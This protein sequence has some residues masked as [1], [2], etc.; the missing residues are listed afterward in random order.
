MK[1]KKEEVVSELGEYSPKSDFS[2]AKLVYDAIQKCIEARGKE[3]KAGYEN[4]KLTKDGLPIT[5]WIPDARQI[6]VGCVVA[7]QCI[8]SSEIISNKNY[9]EKIKG[10]DGKIK[11]N[12]ATHSYEELEKE[13]EEGTGRVKWVKTGQKFIPEIGSVVVMP[14]VRVPGLGNSIKGGWDSKTNLYWSAVI[15]EY[16]KMFSYLN[17]LVNKLNFFKTKPGF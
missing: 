3:M 15:K 13:L 14:S 9:N 10:C 6:Y 5:T 8:L 12:E 17:Q 11:E 2:K 4:T 16:D 1:E 7:L